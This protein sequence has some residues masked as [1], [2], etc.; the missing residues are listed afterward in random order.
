MYMYFSGLD[1]GFPYPDRAINALERWFNA[2]RPVPPGYLKLHG[3]YPFVGFVLGILV[4]G[5]CGL[6]GLLFGVLSNRP[7]RTMR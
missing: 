1:H 2:R 3:E 5:F 4:L 7:D 6:T